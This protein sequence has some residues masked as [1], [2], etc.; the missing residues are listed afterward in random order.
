MVGSMGAGTNLFAILDRVTPS[1]GMGSS[2]VMHGS[3]PSI[4]WDTQFCNVNFA[5]D[6][7]KDYFVLNNFNLDIPKRSAFALVGTF[8]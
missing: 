1:P 7:R 6:S 4:A 3:F 2:N 5:Y 8:N